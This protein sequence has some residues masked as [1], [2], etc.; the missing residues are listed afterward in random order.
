VRTSLLPYQFTLRIQFNF[1]FRQYVKAEVA[2]NFMV[3]KLHLCAHQI[4]SGGWNCPYNNKSVHSS[5][6]Y[7]QTLRTLTCILIIRTVISQ[8]MIVHLVLVNDSKKYFYEHAGHVEPSTSLAE[9][10]HGT[11][12]YVNS[13]TAGFSTHIHVL[14][15]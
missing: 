14:G 10:F 8:V 13:C 9:M 5:S 6:I 12:R 11:S 2:G 7:C 4:V 1:L 15:L 3:A